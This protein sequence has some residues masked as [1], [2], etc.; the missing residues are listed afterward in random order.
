MNLFF[1]IV[2]FYLFIN[3]SLIICLSASGIGFEISRQ[4][5]L[6]G[7]CV[8]L[9]GRRAAVLS[10]AVSSLS[11][12]GI[13]VLSVQGDVRSPADAKRAVEAT[14]DRFGSL[15]MLVNSA[16]GN[17]LAPAEDLNPKGFATVMEI[18]AGG[19]FTMCNAAFP[20]LKKCNDA[21]IINISAMLHQPG[22]KKTE[23]NTTQHSATRFVI[24]FDSL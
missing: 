14:V 13:S 3:F 19:V 21:N 18:D 22:Q 11:S 24:A 7:A 4:L 15:S 8:C 1:P 20:Q 9:M 12:E 23:E 6:H 17:F 10:S 16:A 2:Y 5:G